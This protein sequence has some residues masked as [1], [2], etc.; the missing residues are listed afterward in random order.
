MHRSGTE[1]LPAAALARL[2]QDLGLSA[3]EIRIY[4]FLVER[5]G[6]GGS[7]IARETAMPRGRIYEAMRRLAAKGFVREEPTTPIRFVATPQ[8]DLLSMAKARFTAHLET[9]KTSEALLSKLAQPAPTLVAP[10][11]RPRDVRVL[12]G[13]RAC[14]SEILRMLAQTQRWF[15]LTG[16]AHF[17]KRLSQMP[18]LQEA[19]LASARPGIDVRLFLSDVENRTPS[20][21][22]LR[23]S[24]ERLIHD[25][26]LDP[27]HSQ[28][29]TCANE[30]SVL[31]IIVQPNDAAPSRGDDIGI[32][33]NSGVL[34]DATRR[35][36]EWMDSQRMAPAS[37]ESVSLG[38]LS[39]PPQDVPPVE[40]SFRS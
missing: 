10:V 29:L 34:A 19:F 14:N 36:M 8:R 15:W 39:E 5:G 32:R 38:P 24:L 18:R 31:E 20:M 1:A 26:R 6:A 12:D 3:A 30:A 9:I 27:T 17:G 35:R 13:R 33:I 22:W 7:A 25:I 11:A 16:S 28:I 2:L 4:R 40:I 23:M 37:M 21:L